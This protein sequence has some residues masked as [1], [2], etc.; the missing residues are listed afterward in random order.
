[1]PVSLASSLALFR[2]MRKTEKTTKQ[3][4]AKRQQDPG[5]NLIHFWSAKENFAKTQQVCWHQL[6]QIPV[7]VRGQGELDLANWK[8]VEPERKQQIREGK[9]VLPLFSLTHFSG[10]FLRVLTKWFHV[11]RWNLN[12]PLLRPEKFWIGLVRI[13]HNVLYKTI[14]L[15][16]TCDRYTISHKVRGT[17]TPSMTAKVIHGPPTEKNPRWRQLAGGPYWPCLDTHG[18]LLALANKCLF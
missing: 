15:N 18:P 2:P 11:V 5:G 4:K 14:V 3:S 16:R 9:K 13:L 17:H 1:M 6:P 10:C 8:W 12:S 7:G